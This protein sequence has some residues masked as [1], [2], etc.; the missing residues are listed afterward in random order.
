MEGEGFGGQAGGDESRE[1][2]VRAGDGKD[3]DSGGDG[4]N[5]EGC[6][7]VCYARGSGVGDD[8]D[9]GSGLEVGDKLCG[10]RL[11]VEEVIADGG[12]FDGVVVEKLGGGARVFTGDAIGLAQ[13]S[14]GS[15]GDVLQVADGGGYEVQAGG[16]GGVWD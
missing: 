6:T 14:K 13:D 11:L 8:R 16:N 2:G 9:F 12:G 10:A 15:E 4:G 5:D 7:W 3:V 1:G